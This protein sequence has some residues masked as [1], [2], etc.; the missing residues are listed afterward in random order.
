MIIDIYEIIDFISGGNINNIH[1]ILYDNIIYLI[2]VNYNTAE[3][4][5]GVMRVLGVD[6][7][8]GGKPEN[9]EKNPRST[10]ETNYNNSAYMSSKLDKQHGAI[11]RWSPIQ[12]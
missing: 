2:T 6:F 9:P 10:A 1:Y 11:P 8:E 4:A 12:L 7:T 5:D 3:K